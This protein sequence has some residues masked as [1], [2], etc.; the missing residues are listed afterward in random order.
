M[1]IPNL[2]QSNLTDV[3]NI[4]G[5]ENLPIVCRDWQGQEPE[6]IPE[7]DDTYVF[8]DPDLVEVFNG[9]T[10]LSTG[11]G[12]YIWG[13]TGAGKS[14][15][16]RQWCARTG[17]QLEEVNGHR[18]MMLNDHVGQFV[19]IKDGMVYVHG[20]LAR[21][22]KEGHWFLLNEMD[23]LDPSVLVALNTVLDGSP[24]VITENGGELITPHP[25]FRFIATGNT[26]GGGDLSGNY[27]GANRQNMAF[28]DRFWVI[29]ADYPP[30][31]VE[32]D[33]LSR[34]VPEVPEEVSSKL[35]EIANQVR[36]VVKGSDD[37]D[38]VDPG[39]IDVTF[40]TRT[41]IRWAIN[42]AAFTPPGAPKSETMPIVKRSLG[43]SLLNRA[44]QD[45]REAVY[46]LF[47]A[48][49]GHDFS[50]VAA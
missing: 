21:A 9:W 14:S 28:M 16:I 10:Q 22:L 12:F 18:R 6:N 42:I 19:V 36:A 44:N 26:S 31:A 39:S 50:T 40:S 32:L 46:G 4:P 24:M 20:P 35:I 37:V 3:T 48:E 5:M 47:S 8:Y 25:E 15:F 7:R 33:I 34:V 38:G 43:V 49:F 41:L 45:T 2:M 17:I 13:P 11:D 1:M 27:P 30:E 23:Q 29:E